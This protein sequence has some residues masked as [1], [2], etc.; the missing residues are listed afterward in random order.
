ME[1]HYNY[2][3]VSVARVLLMVT[4]DE[5]SM[6]AKMQMFSPGTYPPLSSRMRQTIV[7][8]VRQG[9]PTLSSISQWNGCWKAETMLKVYEV[10]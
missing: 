2:T 6:A 1:V 10:L 5:L 8:E 4:L 7:P 3:S 9:T